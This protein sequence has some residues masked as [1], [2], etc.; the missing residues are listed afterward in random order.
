MR[1]AKSARSTARALPAGTSPRRPPAPRAS[2]A[3]A[4]P[5]RR[6]PP[7]RG[8]AAEAVGQTSSGEV[9]RLVHRRPPPGASRGGR[10]PPRAGEPARPPRSRRGLPRRS[11]RAESS[12]KASIAV[13]LSSARRAPRQPDDLRPELQLGEPGDERGAGEAGSGSGSRR[14]SRRHAAG[15]RRREPPSAGALSGIAGRAELGRSTS[16]AP[17]TSAAPRAGGVRALAV[18][19]E[20]C[21][22]TA[23]HL[24][25]SSTRLRRGEGPLRAPASTTTIAL[26]QP[27]IT[28]LA[29]GEILLP[30]PVPAGTR[31]PPPRPLDRPARVAFSPG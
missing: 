30:R 19:C 31:S 18:G 2:R 5:L 27:A 13:A 25:P 4:S 17:R 28:R 14:R 21:P 29:P 9:S 24:P 12:L 16:G 15:E 3:A 8:V 20:G 23:I 7:G 1:R 10:R 26:P 22:G 11:S 6:P